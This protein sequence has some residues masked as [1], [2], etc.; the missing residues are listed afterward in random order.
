MTIAYLTHD[1]VNAADAT[2]RAA[3]LGIPLVVLDVRGIHAAADRVV[4][5]LDHLPESVKAG[6]LGEAAAG[7]DLSAVGV[8]SYHMTTREVKAF[9]R[10]GVIVC[11]RLD[12]ALFYSRPL[13]WCG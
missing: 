11:R 6:L 8:H 7:T 12:A 10:A 4:C 3:R 1:E 5:D 13:V 2:R 9:R